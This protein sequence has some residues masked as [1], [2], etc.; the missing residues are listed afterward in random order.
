MVAPD[1]PKKR[2]FFALGIS[3]KITLMAVF[4]LAF[5]VGINL[6]LNYMNFEAGYRKLIKSQFEV[7]GADLKHTIESGLDL[8]LDLVE[9]R[10][11][12]SLLENARVSQKDIAFIQIIS[13][14]QEIL[15]NTEAAS[16]VDPPTL[17]A[18]SAASRHSKETSWQLV[19]DEQIV[20]GLDL[21]NGFNQKV[22]ILVIGYPAAIVAGAVNEV[23]EHLVWVFLLV[24]TGSLCL[25]AIFVRLITRGLLQSLQRMEN[26]LSAAPLD[27][28]APLVTVGG[29][30]ELE[31]AF[32]G[33]QV[34]SRQLA[35][36]L[37]DLQDQLNG[38]PPQTPPDVSAMSGKECGD[39]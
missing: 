1:H 39:V 15:F 20:Q 30:G 4:V 26:S 29:H 12:Q 25:L 21:V 14:D 13:P 28:P 7:V 38:M 9:M 35:E 5:G 32:T 3:T 33:F 27:Q 36:R 24:L 2:P 37:K 19:G 23:R 31:E 18:W 11:I 10:N 6:Y 22:G 17:M 8:G 16:S 34:T